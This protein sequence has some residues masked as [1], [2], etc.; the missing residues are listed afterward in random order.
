MKVW[1]RFSTGQKA[2]LVAFVWFKKLPRMTLCLE[3]IIVL[4]VS[5]W[6][7]RLNVVFSALHLV[8]SCVIR[9]P[10]SMER[11]KVLVSLGENPRKWRLVGLGLWVSDSVGVGGEVAMS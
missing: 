3:I 10:S 11:L 1:G 9:F 8:L 5:C 7:S 6:L 2:G 4:T